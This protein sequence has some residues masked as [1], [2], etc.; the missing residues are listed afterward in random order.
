LRLH[1]L[2]AACEAFLLAS[3][4][5][6][7][8]FLLSS[9]WSPPPRPLMT[10][11][12]NRKF[13]LLCHSGTC[14]S[15]LVDVLSLLVAHAND[16]ELFKSELRMG[17]GSRGGQPG[18]LPSHGN[19]AIRPDCAAREAHERSA[20][21][22]R[23][24]LMYRQVED[25]EVLDDA[26]RASH[27]SV[28]IAAE[29]SLQ[30]YAEDLKHMSDIAMATTAKQLR[31]MRVETQQQMEAFRDRVCA[32]VVSQ[33]RDELEVMRS[34]FGISV[35]EDVSKEVR[36]LQG[37]CLDAQRKV[38]ELT[39]SFAEFVAQTHEAATVMPLTDAHE[40]LVAVTYVQ[41]RMDD[42][43][44]ATASRADVETLQNR[45]RELERVV[46][47]LGAAVGVPHTTATATGSTTSEP[48]VASFLEPVPTS[49]PPPLATS[50]ALAH[51]LSLSNAQSTPASW[52]LSRPSPASNKAATVNASS[53]NVLNGKEQQVVVSSSSRPTPPAPTAAS[54]AAP[55]TCAERL[56][57]S[58]K[59]A[60]EGVVLTE[61]LPDSVAA[62]HQ[63]GAGHI[64]SHVGRVAVATPPAF[65]AALQASE[66][67]PLKLTTYDP[68]QGRV[69]VLTIQPSES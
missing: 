8:L 45:L 6:F 46:A 11:V 3:A 9:Y 44:A 37:M 59:S 66:G 69:R 7:S 54:A 64:I 2:P 19:S 38:Q 33:T 30:T 36:Q 49:A 35:K 41:A 67:Q 47:T 28:L 21:D 29:Q 12:L 15:Y 34:E 5:L 1:F 26:L 17:G 20:A 60:E 13:D 52:S 50:S 48:A 58:V 10:T 68:F 51:S 42:V 32:S 63:L 62:Q 4:L 56:G 18:L 23:T 61:V 22:R 55:K 43:E 31:A 25:P 39:T 16:T 65:E 24:Q 57:V 14:P 53:S 40:A 27:E